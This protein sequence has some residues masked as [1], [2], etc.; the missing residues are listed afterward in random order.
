MSDFLATCNSGK[1]RVSPNE[2]RQVWCARCSQPKCSLA[3]FAATDP[4]AHR[5]ATWRQE[6]FGKPQANLSIPKYAQIAGLDFKD[7]LNKAVRLEISQK[8]GDWSVPEID[9]TDGRVVQAPDETVKQIDEA[10]R[11][12]NQN[13]PEDVSALEDDDAGNPGDLSVD[14]PEPPVEEPQPQQEVAAPAAPVGKVPASPPKPMTAPSTGNTPDRGEIMLGG[15]PRPVDRLKPPEN[16]WAPKPK[17]KYTIVEPGATIV[18]GG[19][20]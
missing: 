6:F 18:L 12:L 15:A 11:Q 14:E 13:R 2:F 5:Q 4:M 20:K 8:R 16:P 10:V 1:I 19:K 7:L 9:I 3:E 17:P